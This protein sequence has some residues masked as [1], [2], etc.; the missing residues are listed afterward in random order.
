MHSATKIRND[1][2]EQV[3]VLASFVTK[4][5]VAGRKVCNKVVC[6]KIV[7]ERVVCDSGVC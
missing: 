2:F 1:C 5:K 4:L 6:D 7:C 3:C